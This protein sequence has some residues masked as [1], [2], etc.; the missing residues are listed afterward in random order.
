MLTPYF[1]DIEFQLSLAFHINHVRRKLWVGFSFA[2][3]LFQMLRHGKS[4][5][6]GWPEISLLTAIKTLEQ[7]SADTL[8]LIREFRESRTE[9]RSVEAKNRTLGHLI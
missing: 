1:S 6:C 2:R 7:D 5:G 8:H 3:L 4:Q 9:E